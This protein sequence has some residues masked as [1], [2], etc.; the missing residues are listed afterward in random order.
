MKKALLFVILVLSFT[1]KAQDF[2]PASAGQH[3]TPGSFQNSLSS[4][5]DGARKSHGIF[6]EKEFG[7]KA[8]RQSAELFFLFQ[9]L[10]SVYNWLWDPLLSGWIIDSKSIEISYDAKNNLT[11][12]VDQVWNGSNWMNSYRYTAIFDV[13]NDQINYTNQVWNGNDWENEELFTSTYDANHHKSTFLYQIWEGS[14][15]ENTFLVTYTYDANHNQTNLVYQ[16]WNGSAWENVYQ[17]FYTY[18]ANSHLTNETEQ[19]WDAGIWENDG[20]ITYTY[21][22]NFK[23][24]RA[25]DEYWNGISWE[26]YEQTTYTYDANQNQIGALFQ[27][28]IGAWEDSDQYTYMYD[29]NHNL[30]GELDQYWNGSDWVRSEQ[31]LFTYDEDNFVTSES[32]RYFDDTGSMVAYGDSSYLY[33]HTVTAIEDLTTDDGEINLFPN[34]GNGKFSLTSRETV[35]ILEVYNMLGEGIYTDTHFNPQDANDIDL[36]LQGKGI[37][38]LQIYIGSKRYTRKVVIQ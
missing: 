36:T 10:D 24:T 8:K 4:K 28:W 13:H 27:F 14:V 2:P 21:D 26:N 32:Y 16:S 3:P 38:F 5:E 29:A 30:I 25:L 18:D 20:R 31:S 35:N 15:W 19:Y 34:P 12:F 22:A 17:I 11:E 23:L 33:F 7:K 1:A 6:F 9:Q 37:Y